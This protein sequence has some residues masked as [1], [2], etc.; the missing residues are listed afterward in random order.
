MT[1]RSVGRALLLG[2]LAWWTWQLVPRALDA[3]RIAGSFLHLVNL[4][5]NEAGS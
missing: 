4:P 5:F 1:V 3:D 2:L